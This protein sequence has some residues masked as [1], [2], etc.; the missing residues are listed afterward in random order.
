M[1]NVLATS[2]LTVAV[3]LLGAPAFADEA[4]PSATPEAAPAAAG[5][6]AAAAPSGGDDGKKIGVGGDVLFMLPLGDLAD[7][8][9]PLVGAATRV[10]YY[11]M[12]E[13][14]AYV[15]SGYQFGLNKSVDQDL[16]PLGKVSFKSSVSNIPVYVGGRYFVM[17]PGAG[18]YGQLE[19]GANLMSIKGEAGG[20]SKSESATR[21]GFN[22]GAGYVISKD[23]PI[24]IGAQF[25]YLNLL[26]TETG[27]KGMF[28]ATIQ[29]GYEARF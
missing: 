29:A 13:F 21:F 24:N 17:Q 7:A 18:L 20:V 1:R 3:V 6:S 25:N 16:G 28:G 15:R 2:A 8:T 27:E 5:A 26:G 10:G 4:H 14:E 12:P 22:L 11:V 23:L 9:G 19:I